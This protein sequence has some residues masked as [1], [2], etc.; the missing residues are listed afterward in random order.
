[1]ADAR[2]ERRA[3]RYQLILHNEMSPNNADLHWL[4]ERATG[5]RDG[6]AT[7]PN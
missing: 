6:G 4:Q 1:M 5:R 7:T 3:R 2:T